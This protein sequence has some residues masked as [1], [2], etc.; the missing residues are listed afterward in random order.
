M[1]LSPFPLY[2]VV[3]ICLVYYLRFTLLLLVQF[4]LRITLL[5]LLLFKGFLLRSSFFFWFKDA[6]ALLC[7]SR[8]KTKGLSD[9]NTTLTPIK[10]LPKK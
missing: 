6:L 3:H 4:K 2:N 10:T 9:K 5:Y 8:N 1:A 7:L